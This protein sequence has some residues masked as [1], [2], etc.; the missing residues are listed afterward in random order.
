MPYSPPAGNAVAFVFST[1]GYS[2]PSGGSVLF[3]FSSSYVPP[4]TPPSGS[5]VN[6]VFSTTGYTPP[7]G[8]AVN[9]VFG[10]GGGGG[11]ITVSGS[12]VVGYIGVPYAGATFTASGG[13]GPYSWSASGLPAGLSINASTGVVGGTP[14][15]SAGTTTGIAITATDS[16]SATGSLTGLSMTTYADDGVLT[17]I[18]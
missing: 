18:S 4:Y 7:S 9:F 17:I 11:S 3:N 5:G 16:T 15:G 1:T 13:T 10:S 8:S 6:F 14:T 2:P 12:L